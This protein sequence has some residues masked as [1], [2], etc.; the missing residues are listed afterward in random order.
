M[1]QQTSFHVFFFGYVLLTAK[2]LPT[3]VSLIPPNEDHSFL[4][5]L[6]ASLYRIC[7]PRSLAKSIKLHSSIGE[8]TIHAYFFSLSSSSLPSFPF[9]SLLLLSPRAPTSTY[10]PINTSTAPTNHLTILT[11]LPCASTCAFAF[12]FLLLCGEVKGR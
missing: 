8:T 3:R 1:Y 11:L 4:S 7:C 10:L 12:F 6:F 5:F 9:H 2:L